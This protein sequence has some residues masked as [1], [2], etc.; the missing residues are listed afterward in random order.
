MQLKRENG[1]DKENKIDG[2]EIPKESISLT[3]V[4]VFLGIVFALLLIMVFYLRFSSWSP[5]SGYYLKKKL[6]DFSIA[7]VF[8]REKTQ[9]PSLK[10]VDLTITE[11]ELAKSINITGSDFPLKKPSLKIKPEGIV[12]S[13]KTSSGFW[14]VPVEV[15]FEPKVGGGMLLFNIKEIKAAGVVAPPKIADSLTPKMN[16][17][18]YNAFSGLDNL[19][20]TGARTLVGYM[21]LEVGR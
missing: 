14:G 1:S 13:G 3:A 9:S 6:P 19:K 16:S 5:L 8:N 21:I 17:V 7:D 10:E 4:L 18:F 20:I 12:I 15:V 11:E 2:V